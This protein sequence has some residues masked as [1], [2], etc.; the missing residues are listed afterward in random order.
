MLLNTENLFINNIPCLNLDY[1]AP[2]SSIE[3]GKVPFKPLRIMVI[4]LYQ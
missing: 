2:L 1:R 4:V 3:K